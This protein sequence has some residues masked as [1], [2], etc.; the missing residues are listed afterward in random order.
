MIRS[1]GIRALAIA[2]LALGALSAAAVAEGPYPT[3]PIK[4]IVPFPAGSGTDI[5][6]RLIGDELA[7]RLGQPI[8]IENQA[9][10]GTVV[11]TRATASAE[12]DGHTLFLTT[13]AHAILPSL[14]RQLPFNVVT[15]FTPVM[16]V[17]AGPLVLTAHPSFPANNIQELIQL[18]KSK[19]GQINY[20]SSGTGTAPHLA[21]EL[22]KVK[23]GI[24]IVHVP[25]RGGAPA[26]NDV[27]AGHVSLYFAAPATALPHVTS[28]GVR[29][30]GQS[31]A[32]RSELIKD[33]PTLAEQGVTGYNVELWYGL[34]GPAKLPPAVVVRLQKEVADILNMAEVRKTLQGLG[35]QPKPSSSQQFAD[36]IQSE[37]QQWA[38]VAKAA[39]LSGN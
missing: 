15:D 19:P 13:S 32:E 27:L 10:G 4:M 30:L 25:Y 17:C 11:A 3:R 33:I 29:A 36:Y 14:H 2:G 31:A 18:A 20:A 34:L 23:T 24:D 28:G 38:E 8:V 21:V 35:F 37:L 16:L 12:P 9:G 5:V 22:L 26:M 1:F 7:R 6:A 39:N